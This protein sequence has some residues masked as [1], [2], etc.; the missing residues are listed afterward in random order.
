MVDIWE[1]YGKDLVDNKPASWEWFIAPIYSDLG[2]CFT[3]ISEYRWL[4]MVNI[5]GI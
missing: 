1:I 2:D 4:Y 3:H 5:D